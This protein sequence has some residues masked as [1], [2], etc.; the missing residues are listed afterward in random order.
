MI[1]KPITEIKERYTNALSMYWS[2]IVYA[3]YLEK[4]WKKLYQI[5]VV[6]FEYVF[7]KKKSYWNNKL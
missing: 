7:I 5:D 6:N 3:E 1:W 2:C 4:Y